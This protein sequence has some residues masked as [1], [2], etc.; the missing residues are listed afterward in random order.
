[1]SERMGAAA[2]VPSTSTAATGAASSHVSARDTP[3]G[4]IGDT[5]SQ[6]VVPGAYAWAVTV[7]PAA[8][9]SG[10]SLAAKGGALA[11]LLALAAGAVLG[12][13][14]VSY[15]RIVSLW[16]F[17]LCCTASWIAVPG[18]AL[19]FV[20][21]TGLAGILGWALFAFASAAPSLARAEL[22][23][24]ER[25]AQLR[26]R[27]RAHRDWP[28]LVAALLVALGFQAFGWGIEEAERAVFARVICLAASVASLLLVT[29]YLETRGGELSVRSFA[30]ALRTLLAALAIA[31]ASFREWQNPEGVASRVRVW[32]SEVPP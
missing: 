23:Q 3:R 7:A 5:S 17:V 18:Y 27:T 6:V 20:P 12:W 28:Q 11:A 26:P 30:P 1:M 9:T 25:E 32:A 14:K 4:W 13:K 31:G 21:T 22:P 29:R 19:T 2:H 10:A 16:G 15:A 8:W 24:A